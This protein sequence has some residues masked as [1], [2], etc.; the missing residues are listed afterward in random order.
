MGTL[1]RALKQNSR[2]IAM[3]DKY[4][5]GTVT[6]TRYLSI[7]KVTVTWDKK[8]KGADGKPLPPCVMDI[9]TIEPYRSRFSFWWSRFFARITLSK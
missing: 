9:D 4:L 1:S 7:S 6:N 2:V 3:G 5:S 8:F